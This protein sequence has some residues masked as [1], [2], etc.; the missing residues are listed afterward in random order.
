MA[1]SRMMIGRVDGNKHYAP[2]MHDVDKVNLLLTAMH[3]C[4][5]ATAVAM[6]RD[7]I[8]AWDIFACLSLASSLLRGISAVLDDRPHDDCPACS[9]R[10]LSFM[11]LFT[12]TTIPSQ[13]G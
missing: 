3:V 4:C 11:R 13:C 1:P 12:E 9:R 8:S 2:F 7:D 6:Q 10:T 5:I